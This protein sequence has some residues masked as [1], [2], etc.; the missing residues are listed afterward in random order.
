MSRYGI[1]AVYICLPINTAMNGKSIWFQLIVT[2]H[3]PH[4]IWTLYMQTCERSSAIRVNIKS[5]Y[6]FVLIDSS[7]QSVSLSSSYAFRVS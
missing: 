1:V 5:Q 7:F 3:V 4:K 2:I 6:Y